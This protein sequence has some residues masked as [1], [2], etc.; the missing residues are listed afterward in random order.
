LD[1]PE[2]RN[3]KTWNGRM[4]FSCLADWFGV[5]LG[6]LG[7]IRCCVLDA[8]F[9]LGHESGKGAE[10]QIGVTIPQKMLVK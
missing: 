7:S 4:F 6:L 8:C 1:L 2:T 5:K 9:F 3:G 10:W